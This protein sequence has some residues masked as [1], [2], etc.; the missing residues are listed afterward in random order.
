M[1]VKFLAVACAGVF[2]AAAVVEGVK[3]ARS[4]GEAKGR[5]AE[6]GEPTVEAVTIDA[7]REQA[8]TRGETETVPWSDPV[9]N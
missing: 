8:S 9:L 7:N 2:V 1:L 5:P 3:M 6:D 4:A